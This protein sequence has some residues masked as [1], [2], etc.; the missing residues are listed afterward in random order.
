MGDEIASKIVFVCSDIS[1]PVLRSELRSSRC[2]SPTMDRHCG[3]CWTVEFPRRVFKRVMRQI[4]N[5]EI[6]VNEV[7]RY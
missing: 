2:P 4:R 3:A 7:I 6:T 1:E 5:S